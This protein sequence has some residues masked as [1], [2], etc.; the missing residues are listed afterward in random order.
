M[1]T[2]NKTDPRVIA[3]RADVLVVRGT[4]SSIDECYSDSELVQYL[5]SFDATTPKEAVVEAR[6]A[7]EIYLEDALNRRWGEDPDPEL[8]VY[9]EWVA[10]RKAAEEV[11]V[12]E[13]TKL[14]CPKGNAPTCPGCGNWNALLSESREEG[15]CEDGYTKYT[16][17][18]KCRDCGWDVREDETEITTN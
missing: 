11:E 7:E 2:E 5:D 16:R 9:N 13:K 4:G 6:E 14:H 17:Y 8:V 3:V 15:K 12:P 1:K 10:K 18:L